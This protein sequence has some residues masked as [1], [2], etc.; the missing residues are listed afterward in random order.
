M[1]ELFV[2]NERCIKGG[3]EWLSLLKKTSGII[4]WTH[5]NEQPKKKSN[6]TEINKEKAKKN[7]KKTD[8]QTKREGSGKNRGISEHWYTT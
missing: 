8:I 2:V 7:K 1:K 4:T 6:I 5:K 3:G